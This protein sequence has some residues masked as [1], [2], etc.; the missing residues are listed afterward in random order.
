LA[1][2]PFTPPPLTLLERFC[3]GVLLLD[4]PPPPPPQ[5]TSTSAAVAPKKAQRHLDSGYDELRMEAFLSKVINL[6]FENVCFLMFFDRLGLTSN[7]EPQYRRLWAPYFLSKNVCSVGVAAKYFM[8][9]PL[10]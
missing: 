3:G 9:E 4:P 1:N 2:G 5:P 7:R 10:I 8:A 6:V